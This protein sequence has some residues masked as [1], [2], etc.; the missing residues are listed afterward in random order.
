LR[1]GDI[2]NRSDEK[3]P[4]KCVCIVKKKTDYYVRS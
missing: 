1:S 3:N 2:T 4:D